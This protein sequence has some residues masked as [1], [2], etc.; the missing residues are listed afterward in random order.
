[1]HTDIDDALAAL[2]RQPS[3]NGLAGLE[4]RVLRAIEDQPTAAFGAGMTLTA[5]TLA[6]AL[7][8]VSNVVPSTRANAAPTLAP[9]GAPSAL[10]PST[11]LG[12]AR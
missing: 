10:A 4:D 12:E 7:G 8:V 11:L 2:G 9:F 6:L 5:V 3:H 1:M